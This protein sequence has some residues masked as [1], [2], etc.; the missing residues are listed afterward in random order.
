MTSSDNKD[1]FVGYGRPPRHS[2]FNPGVSGNPTGRPKGSRNWLV[3]LINELQADIE[4]SENGRN[5][6]I[7]K[8][9]AVLRTLI[10]T[11]A[12]GDT[13]A[14]TSVLQLCARVLAPSDRF[15]GFS[16]AE[17]A[18]IEHYLER[19]A[20]RLDPKGDTNG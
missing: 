2:R 20:E 8:Q 19:K 3:D 9:R 12:K 4:I 18:A 13:R 7:S 15:E 10:D 14:A 5:V 1:E 17:K 16:D 6:R 11:A